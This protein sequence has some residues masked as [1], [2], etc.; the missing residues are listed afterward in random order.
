MYNLGIRT[1]TNRLYFSHNF[2]MVNEIY[3]SKLLRFVHSLHSI[4]LPA[5]F[6][7][8]LLHASTIHNYGT[9]YARGGIISL[10]GY[11]ISMDHY[12]HLMWEVGYGLKF[13]HMPNRLTKTDLR[14]MHLLT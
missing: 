2:L 12:H 1:N 14:L 11:T 8:F 6:D 10:L 5:A 13:H 3:H 9:R 4:S 7:N